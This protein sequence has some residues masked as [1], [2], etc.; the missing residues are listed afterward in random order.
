MRLP[1]RKSRQRLWKQ[2]H[3]E[4]EG[5][6]EGRTEE[7]P[8]ICTPHRGRQAPPLEFTPRPWPTA[9][10]RDSK[11]GM[12][13][14]TPE[15]EAPQTPARLS[16]TVPRDAGAY[17]WDSHLSGASSSSGW[18]SAPRSK[19]LLSKLTFSS[20]MVAVISP[21]SQTE[22]HSSQC[23]SDTAPQTGDSRQHSGRRPPQPLTPPRGPVGT[24]GG[25]YQQTLR[26]AASLSII[27]ARVRSHK[28]SV[29]LKEV[30]KPSPGDAPGSQA[31]FRGPGHSRH[32]RV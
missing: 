16:Q 4:T 7:A 15:M 20:L 17:L 14:T 28:R 22:S 31:A 24:G 19:Q 1:R 12:V 6:T 26:H 27:S 21:E 30:S 25:F 32:R 11:S 23:L 9:Q 10:T 8:P 18:R 3:W 2:F 13:P 5:R 29:S